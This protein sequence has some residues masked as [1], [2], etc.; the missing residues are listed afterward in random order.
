MLVKRP[1]GLLVI[2]FKTDNIAAGEV[3]ERAEVYRRQL[4]L[5]SRAVAAILAGKSVG[6]WLYFLTPGCAIEVK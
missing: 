2:D 1:A 5:Y 6:K 4:E 3:D